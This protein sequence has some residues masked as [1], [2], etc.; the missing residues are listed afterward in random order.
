MLRFCGG[1][2]TGRSEGRVFRVRVRFG[3]APVSALLE[4]E[5]EFWF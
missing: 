1:V 2:G 5:L 4:L 3:A